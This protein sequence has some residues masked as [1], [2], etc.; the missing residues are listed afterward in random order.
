MGNSTKTRLRKRV[1]KPV[2]HTTAKKLEAVKRVNILIHEGASQTNALDVVS[3]NLGVTS[4]TVQNWRMK[5]E[6]VTMVNDNGSTT[7]VRPAIST[8]KCTVHSIGLRTSSGT[9]IHLALEDI[10]QIAHLAG[11][12]S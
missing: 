5:F 2:F 4:Q 6:N 12:I 3:T 11:F 7:L 8:N 10:Q 9:D 1:G